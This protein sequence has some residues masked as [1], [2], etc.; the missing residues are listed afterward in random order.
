MVD[1]WV[2][3]QALPAGDRPEGQFLSMDLD[4][5]PDDRTVVARL[6]G[7]LDLEHAAGFLRW[8][9]PLCEPPRRLVLDLCSVDFVDSAGIRALM[10]FHNRLAEADGELVLIVAPGSRVRRTLGLLQLESTFHMEEC[11]P[12]AAAA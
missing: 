1:S 11:P 3:G 4:E 9:E 10:H 6:A 8:V 5:S 7:P 12:Q 2:N